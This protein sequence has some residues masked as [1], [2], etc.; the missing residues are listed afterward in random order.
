MADAAPYNV[1]YVDQEHHVVVEKPVVVLE[2]ERKCVYVGGRLFAHAPQAMHSEKLW[3]SMREALVE[4]LTH[5][6]ATTR[7]LMWMLTAARKNDPLTALDCGLP[8]T[9]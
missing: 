4:H 9:L 2:A 1:C 7:A 8:L 6:E 5:R 3:S